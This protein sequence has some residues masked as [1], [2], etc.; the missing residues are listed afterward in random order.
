MDEVEYDVVH[1]GGRGR[2]RT[3]QRRL[4]CYYRVAHCR[5]VGTIEQSIELMDT[6]CVS[7][8]L[9]TTMGCLGVFGHRFYHDN[10]EASADELKR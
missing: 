5:C 9:Y 10:G 4:L 8:V 1:G 6:S 7:D 2:V 3:C